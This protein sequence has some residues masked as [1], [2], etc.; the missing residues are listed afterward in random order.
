MRVLVTGS[1]GFLGRR[2]VVALRQ[3]HHQ[4]RA[5][6]MS[7]GDP[8]LLG[9]EGLAVEHFAADLCRSAR[10]DEALANVDAV[11]HLAAQLRGDDA[12]RVTNTVEGTRRLLD[13][14]ERVGTQR[15]ILASSFVVYDW[16]SSERVL[17]EDSPLEVNPERRDGYAIAKI[18][19]EKLV[20][21]RSR[22]NGWNLTVLRPG[23]MWG[24]GHQCLAV[25]GPKFGKVQ[26]VIGPRRAM[27][28]IHVDNCADVF[29]AVLADPRA[30]GCTFNVVDHLDIS[31]WRHLGEY[32]AR[33]GHRVI[34]VPFAYG[35]ARMLVGVIYG[36]ARLARIH[37]GLPSIL[38]PWRFEARFKPLAFA[39][40][41]LVKVMAW[42]PPL[43]YQQCLEQGY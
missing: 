41:G 14:M 33:S 1:N 36:C 17:S 32:L 31:A 11:V 13:A 39:R 9:W 3:R 34:P 2:V 24:P 4:V 40:S 37:R 20:V 8:A 7:C 38:V 15:L 43:S 10:L 6:D 5:L 30:A 16:S 29:A 12:S 21:D 18:R 28:L 22:A 19:Q 27:P 26:M 25:I 23:A 35:P 42:T